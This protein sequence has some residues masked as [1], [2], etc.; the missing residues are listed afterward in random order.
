MQQKSTYDRY[1]PSDY[2]RKR[3][4]PHDAHD[5]SKRKPFFETWPLAIGYRK[6]KDEMYG[7]R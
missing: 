1:H 4:N 7:P 2:V 6:H 5:E 3:S